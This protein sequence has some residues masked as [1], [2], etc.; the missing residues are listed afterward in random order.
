LLS[1]LEAFLQCRLRPCFEG[2]DTQKWEPNTYKA[3]RCQ[4]KKRSWQEIETSYFLFYCT[5]WLS[6]SVDLVSTSGFRQKVCT[7]HLSRLNSH[8]TWGFF[9]FHVSGDSRETRWSYSLRPRN[10]SDPLYR[11]PTQRCG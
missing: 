1:L 6:K 9:A 10:N 8:K 2:F 3:S 5:F 7:K 11:P 4:E